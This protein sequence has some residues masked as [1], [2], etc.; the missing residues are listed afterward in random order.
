MAHPFEGLDGA[1]RAEKP[2][3][4][5]LTMMIDWGLGRRVQEDILDTAAFAFDFAKVAVGMSRLLKEEALRGKIADYQKADVEPFPGGQFF[6]YAETLEKTEQ[7]LPAVKDVGYRWVEVSDNMAEVT[8][9]WKERMIREAVVDFGLKVLG[10]VG[11]KEGLA[12][13][14][15]FVDDARRCANAGASVVLLEAA[16]LVGDDADTARDVEAVVKELGI[17]RVM[18][19]LPGPWIS[20]VSH[21]DVHAMR[22]DL[23]SRYGREV[24]LGNVMPDEVMSVEAYRRGLGVNAGEALG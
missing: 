12:S 23:I 8:L 15:S 9:E 22:R 13:D 6:E 17:D 24:N 1:A 16:E 2:R 21:H 10:E 3:S 4:V 5:G 14:T 20:G 19:E 7:Y 11:K 18:F